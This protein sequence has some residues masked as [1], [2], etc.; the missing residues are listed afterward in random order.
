VC[1]GEDCAGIDEGEVV[2]GVGGE[3]LR[4]DVGCIGDRGVKGCVDGDGGREVGELYA[5]YLSCGW[6]CGKRRSM[7]ERVWKSE[8]WNEHVS[9]TIVVSNVFQ[10]CNVPH[11]LL[12]FN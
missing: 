9:V 3:K 7:L 6:H 4:A 11:T 8:R 5:R 1:G 10:N 2:V 12:E